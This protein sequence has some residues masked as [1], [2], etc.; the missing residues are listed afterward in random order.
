MVIARGRDAAD[1]APTIASAPPA[2]V[3]NSN[4]PLVPS[5]N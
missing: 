2:I 3:D 4:S 1:V 5:G